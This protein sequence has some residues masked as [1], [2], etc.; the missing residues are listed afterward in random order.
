MKHKVIETII[1]GFQK[2]KGKASCYCFDKQLTC[3]IITNVINK[4]KAKRPNSSIFIVVDSYNTRQ[5]IVNYINKNNIIISNLKIISADYIQGKYRY[6]Y[7]L[8]I[9]VGVINFSLLD[10]FNVESNYTLSIFTTH[11]NDAN[12]IQIIRNILPNIDIVD[13]VNKTKIANVY[14]PVEEHRWGVD[15]T[16]DNQKLYDEYTN[17][18][19]ISVTIFGNLD[20]IEKCKHGDTNTNISAAEF[21]HTIA[22]NNG[23]SENLDT[24]IPFIKQ[25]DDTYNPNVLHERAINFY[26]IAKKRRD[27]LDSAEEKLEV[28]KEICTRH[29]GKKILIISKKGQFAELVTN[30]LNNNGIPCGSY[31]DDIPNAIAIDENGNPK[32]YK[33]GKHKGELKEIGAQAQSSLNQERFNC[34]KINTLS[35][36]FSS[37]TKLKI[38]ADIIILTT[39]L[40]DDI[41]NIKKRY[42]NIEFTNNPTIV[43]K[44]YCNNTIETTKLNQQNNVFTDIINETENSVIIDK[45]NGDII[46]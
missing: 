41:V 24:T 6:V 43:Y 34:M 32:V 7:D 15:F 21:R 39:T 37:N 29:I 35:I 45:N 44:I 19:N 42:T 10:K 9:S 38:A 30:Y 33:I 46:L 1:D 22:K 5:C 23:W 26:N 11:I 25:I 31:H 13:L 8:I 14:S 3:E 18:I 27:L 16:T 17:Y 40:Y 4:F 2:N 20:N 12:L 36:K 28:I